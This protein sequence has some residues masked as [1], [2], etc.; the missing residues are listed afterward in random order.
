MIC[1]PWSRVKVVLSECYDNL[2][3]KFSWGLRGRIQ[4]AIENPPILRVEITSIEARTEYCGETEPRVPL[5]VCYGAA[6]AGCCDM[7]SI[8]GKSVKAIIRE[9]V[10]GSAG[11]FWDGV[12]TTG[13]VRFCIRGEM[14]GEPFCFRWERGVLPMREGD[15]EDY[16]LMVCHAMWH[17]LMRFL[18]DRIVAGESNE[19]VEGGG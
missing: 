18:G 8:G 5:W 13:V 6:P 19:G 9:V 12:S 2:A 3:G 16:L 10:R 7:R 1:M 17:D 4:G 15:V 14:D 11:S